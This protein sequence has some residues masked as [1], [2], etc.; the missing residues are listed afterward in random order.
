MSAQRVEVAEAA[1]KVFSESTARY[2]RLIV[3]TAAR[4]SGCGFRLRL[5][6]PSL[7]QAQ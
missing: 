2:C 1:T 6:M 7:Y 3:V 5:E 4:K